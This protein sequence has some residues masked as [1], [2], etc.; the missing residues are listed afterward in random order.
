MNM[1]KIVIVFLFTLVLSM[2]FVTHVDARSG[3]CSHH[4]G[5]CGCG[6]CD[7]T[8]LS[9]T[10]APYYP[11]CTGSSTTNTAPVYVVPTYTP[12]PTDTPEPTFTPTPTQKL[13]VK[14]A[15]AVKVTPIKK[16]KKKIVK[17]IKPTP[18]PE[19]NFWQML[20]GI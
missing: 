18:T 13:L 10:C 7:G 19:K 20:F 17:I 2:I 1:M 12:I 14:H 4:G 5:V 8:S 3:C 9:Q 6:C 16:P 15:P 11:E